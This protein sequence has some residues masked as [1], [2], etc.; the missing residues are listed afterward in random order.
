MGFKLKSG[1]TSAFKMMGSSPVKQRSTKGGEAQ[2]QDKIFDAKGKHVGTY[3]NGKKVMKSTKSAHG[4]LDDAKR[5]FDADVLRKNRKTT[6]PSKSPAKQVDLSKKTGLGPSAA[7]GGSKNRELVRDK[8]VKTK[9][10]MKDGPK[11]RVHGVE[12]PGNWQPHQFNSPA[13]QLKGSG[14]GPATKFDKKRYPVGNPEL[15]DKNPFNKDDYYYKIDG[16]ATTKAAYLKYKNK[17]GNME[18]GG[19]QTNNPDVYGRKKGGSPS[20]PK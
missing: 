6:N 10:V 15:T 18:G 17:P 4:Q 7:F 1:N 14:H 2:D 8:Q 3:V 11:N 16:K 20:N 9:K 5:D 12:N 19:K 13:K